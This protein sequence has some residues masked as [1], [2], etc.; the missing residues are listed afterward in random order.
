VPG[1][2]LLSQLNAVV[3]WRLVSEQPKLDGPTCEQLGLAENALR[4]R[5]TPPSRERRR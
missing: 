5:C 4:E 2:R 3:L 1:R